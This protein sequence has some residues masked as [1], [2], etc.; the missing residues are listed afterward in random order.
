MSVNNNEEKSALYHK[1]N[2]SVNTSDLNEVM[3][4][5]ITRV[6]YYPHNDTILATYKCLHKGESSQVKTNEV[7][8]RRM[9]TF[10][11]SKVSIL[12]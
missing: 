3:Q 5:N 9:C 11:N 4:L 1:L 7:L 8:Q 2:N 10:R 6:L 12:E